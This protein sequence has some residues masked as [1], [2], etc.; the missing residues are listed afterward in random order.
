MEE[1][2]KSSHEWIYAIGDF[3]TEDKGWVLL[4][5]PGKGIAKVTKSDTKP[6]TKAQRE[7]LFGY[8]IDRG[9]NQ[10]AAEYL[11]GGE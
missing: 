5:N 8:Y 1:F 4:H 11:E 3:L 9:L 10:M 6:L 2:S 7:F